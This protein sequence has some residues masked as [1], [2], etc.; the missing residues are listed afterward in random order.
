MWY[1]RGMRRREF[2]DLYHQHPQLFEQMLALREQG[3]SIRDIAEWIWDEYSVRITPSTIAQY[4]WRYKRLQAQTGNFWD[5]ERIRRFPDEFSRCLHIYVYAR[6]LARFDNALA[7]RL[8][9]NVTREMCERVVAQE[10]G[11]TLPPLGRTGTRY[12]NYTPVESTVL[13]DCRL[14]RELSLEELARRARVQNYTLSKWERYGVLPN[15]LD[16]IDRIAQALGVPIT[17]LLEDYHAYRR[18]DR[19][20]RKRLDSA[21]AEM[22]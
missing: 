20:S 10:R 11:E 9:E 13:R 18:L 19:V 4:L 8:I 12:M 16:T 17:T 21:R 15:S 7:E 6:S 1:N 3:Y 14:K 2:R 5:A 22:V